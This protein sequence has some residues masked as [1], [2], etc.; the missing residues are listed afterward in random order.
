[1]ENNGPHQN[2]E[3]FKALRIQLSNNGSE[4]RS[5]SGCSEPSRWKL[6]GFSTVGDP[7]FTRGFIW[8][9]WVVGFSPKIYDS[10]FLCRFCVESFWF[11]HFPHLPFPP[12][13]VVVI[14][15]VQFAFLFVLILLVHWMHA[16]VV[17]SDVFPC[18]CLLLAWM[19]SY[20]NMTS[21][22]SHFP[23]PKSP[24]AVFWKVHD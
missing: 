10:I 22:F 7:A 1:M 16:C 19:L 23:Y 3:N 5:L 17:Y 8:P 20:L 15:W 9:Y 14:F 21:F 18:N 12:M 13:P 4:E 24:V 6:K 2:G 11:L